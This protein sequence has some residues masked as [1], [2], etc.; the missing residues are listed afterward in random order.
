MLE[1]IS[2]EGLYILCG[3]LF[4]ADE[5]FMIMVFDKIHNL[6]KKGKHGTGKNSS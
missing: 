1:S 4:V 5:I 2:N 6:R 3:V